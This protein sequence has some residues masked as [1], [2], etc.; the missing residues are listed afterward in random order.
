MKK[1]LIL[2][3][4]SILATGCAPGLYTAAALARHRPHA[5]HQPPAEPPPVGRWDNVMMLEPGTPLKLLTMDGTVVTGRFVSA[6]IKAVTLDS[7]ETTS[8]AVGDVMRIDRVGTAAGILTKEGVKGAAVG[9]GVAGV[10]GLLLG[11]TPP[12]R[13]F[14]GAAVAG[15]YTGAAAASRT[16][17]PGTIYLASA[18]GRS[19]SEP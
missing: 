5:V 10:A 2:L 7:A 13:V 1:L 15:A 18:V 14:A 4:P 16:P 12:P 9:A 6:N 8:V 3:V 11:V 19:G 17:G